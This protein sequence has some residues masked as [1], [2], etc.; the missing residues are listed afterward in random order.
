M[1]AHAQRGVII[2]QHDAEQEADVQEQGVEVP[3]Q[4][5]L[6]PELD[7]IGRGVALEGGDA[8]PVER[9]GIRIVPLFVIHVEAGSQGKKGP[10]LE[11][12]AQPVVALSII[13]HEAHGLGLR[14]RLEGH[15]E[16]D[17]VFIFRL[18][19]GFHALLAEVRLDKGEELPEILRRFH[20][21]LSQKGILWEVH[22]FIINEFRGGRQGCHNAQQAVLP[23]KG[24]DR[25]LHRCLRL[26][27][28][29]HHTNFQRV[30]HQ[31][32]RVLHRI[33]YA[34]FCFFCGKQIAVPIRSGFPL[35]FGI[36]APMGAGMGKQ[37]THRRHRPFLLYPLLF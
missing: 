13:A 26:T 30:N 5:G 35:V 9:K 4:G 6:V 32:M 25:L 21:F 1:P 18:P 36:A 12:L 24:P 3:D 31:R 23:G 37:V 22:L 28:E 27:P 16:S 33:V 7:V 11:Q 14:I 8:L 29:Q 17:L 34:G 19:D 10:I 15:C 20:G 2:G